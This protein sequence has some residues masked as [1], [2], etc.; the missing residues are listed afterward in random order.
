MCHIRDVNV[1]TLIVKSYI[2]TA[3]MVSIKLRHWGWVWITSILSY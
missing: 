1:D 2:G 3:Y